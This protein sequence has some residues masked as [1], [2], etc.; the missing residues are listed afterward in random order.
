MIRSQV[1]VYFR[2]AAIFSQYLSKIQICTCFYA[3]VQNLVKIG[4]SAAKLLHIFDF[5]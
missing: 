5:Q 3:D 2:M 4:L 1:I